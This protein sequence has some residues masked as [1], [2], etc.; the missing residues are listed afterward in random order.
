MFRLKQE[1]KQNL[2]Q[3]QKKAELLEEFLKS[4]AI[5]FQAELKER[6]TIAEQTLLRYLKNSTPK[7][8]FQAIIPL[9]KKVGKKAYLYKFFIADFCWRQIKLI[10]ELDGRHH[11]TSTQSKKDKVRTSFLRKEGYKVVRIDNNFILSTSKSDIL[12]LI[13]SL[14]YESKNQEIGS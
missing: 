5:K 14:V 3:R 1:K 13:N 9:Y 4:K 7:V 12:T 8:E 11:Y 10:I 2:L 6:A